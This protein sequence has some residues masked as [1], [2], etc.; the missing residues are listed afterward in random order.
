MKK[1]IKMLLMVFAVALGILLVPGTAS[2]AA[3]VWNAN[4]KQ[5]DATTDSVSLQWSTC[6]GADFYAVEFSPDKTKWTQMDTTSNPSVKITRLDPGS[7]WWVRVI[8]KEGYQFVDGGSTPIVESVPIQVS[9]LPEVKDVENLQQTN[10]TTTSVTMSWSAVS[11]ATSYDVYRY[12]SYGDY[13]KVGADVKATSYTATG[14][15]ASSAFDYFVIAKAKSATGF[16]NQS[17]SYR[18]VTMRTVPGKVQIVAI[19]NFWSNINIAEYKWTAVNNVSGYQFQL[20]NNKNKTLYTKDTGSTY[21][22]SVSVDPYKKGVF[23]KARV[24]AYILVGTKK[25]YGA[26]SG[27]N[28]NAST[29]KATAKRSKN[30]KKI[31]LKWSKVTG[32]SGYKVLVSTKENSGFKKVKTLS[33]KK[34]SITVTKCGKSKLKKSKKYYFRIQYLTKSG[35]KTITS[36]IMGTVSI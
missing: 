2:K 32:A 28:Y 9:T 31:T 22:N 24:R 18:R 34:T 3:E 33:S 16:E 19:S 27:Y 26:W 36:G 6:L 11:G 23:T 20:L 21:S 35:K 13:T 12:N 17:E 14:L 30:G 25:L 15:G 4:L 8:A 7:Q 1:E 5:T 10:A 29:K